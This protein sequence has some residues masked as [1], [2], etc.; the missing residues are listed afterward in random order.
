M[1][2]SPFRLVGVVTAVAL[3]AT[4]CAEASV[5]PTED[6]G[7]AVVATTSILGDVLADVV[8]DAGEVEVLMGPGADPHTFSPSAAQAAAVRDADVVVSF[9]L[10]LEESLID[11]LAAAEAAGVTVVELSSL[12]DTIP[13]TDGVGHADE[14]EAEAEDEEHADE[15]QDPHLWFDPTRMATAI[16]A[17]V[18]SLARDATETAEIGARATAVATEL[19]ELDVEL[20]QILAVIPDERRVLVTNHDA[21]GYFAARYDLR[22]VGTVI[23]GG[24][25]LASASADRLADLTALIR[26]LGVT[27][28]FAENTTDDRLAQSLA[29]EVGAE[30]TVVELYTDALG[31]EGSGA[32]TYAGLLRTDAQLIADA[33]TR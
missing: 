29:R 12:V 24:S 13:V 23:P 28:V 21:I 25:T 7:L 6:D 11:L 3:A 17:L 5:G 33:L 1:P 20:T 15:P 14:A 8:G 31:P 27:A 30:V 9:G 19:R 22:L 16:E 18:P 26:E 32:E 10:G 2:R 4:A